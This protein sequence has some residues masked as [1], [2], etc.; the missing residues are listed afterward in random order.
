MSCR[1]VHGHMG[2]HRVTQGFMGIS[3]VVVRS[4]GME[5]MIEATV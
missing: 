3:Q 5:K 4:G 2:L 1:I